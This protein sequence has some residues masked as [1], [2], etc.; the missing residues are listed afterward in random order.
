MSHNATHGAPKP[1]K[2]ANLEGAPPAKSD[3]MSF[4]AKLIAK[5]TRILLRKSRITQQM[6]AKSN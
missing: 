4:K 3:S 2:E 1:N 6:L 5:L